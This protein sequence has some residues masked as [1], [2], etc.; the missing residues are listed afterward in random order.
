M[1][2]H[3]RFKY[4]HWFIFILMYVYMNYLIYCHLFCTTTMSTHESNNVCLLLLLY[5]P[6]E[7]HIL[8]LVLL[9]MHTLFCM[10]EV[11]SSFL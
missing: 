6:C 1:L 4:C 7:G 5:L 8:Y 9:R 11:W 10:Q 2:Y 3:L